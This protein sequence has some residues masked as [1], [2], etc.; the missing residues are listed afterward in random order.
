MVPKIGLEK[1][2]LLRKKE[3]NIEYLEELK[4]FQGNTSTMHIG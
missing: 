3:S 2:L 4:T 1:R